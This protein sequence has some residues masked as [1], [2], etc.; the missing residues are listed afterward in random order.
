MRYG[1][2]GHLCDM[3]DYIL[4]DNN[5]HIP[6]S[7]RMDKRMFKPALTDIA[8]ANPDCPLFKNRSIAGMVLEWAVHNLCYYLGIMKERTGSVDLD[9]PR[10]WYWR[11]AYNT[12][13]LIAWILIP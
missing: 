6:N 2:F 1:L 5:L 4:S 12:L 13:G 8:S 3:I 10:A 9:Y 11:L 7:Y